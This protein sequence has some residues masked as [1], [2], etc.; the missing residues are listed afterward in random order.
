MLSE[1]KSMAL[2]NCFLNVS[3]NV[4]NKEKVRKDQRNSFCSLL[5]FIFEAKIYDVIFGVGPAAPTRNTFGA[6]FGHDRPIFFLLLSFFICFQW[7]LLLPLK[8]GDFIKCHSLESTSRRKQMIPSKNDEAK[9]SK[10]HFTTQHTMFM[11]DELSKKEITFF[12]LFSLALFMCVIDVWMCVWKNFSL[13]VFASSSLWCHR[14][15]FIGFAYSQ[16]LNFRFGRNACSQL[17][18]QRKNGKMSRFNSWL[19]ISRIQIRFKFRIVWFSSIQHH[20]WDWAVWSE[21]RRASN[22]ENVLVRLNLIYVGVLSLS[23]SSFWGDGQW[24]SR[25]ANKC[26]W[27]SNC[28]YFNSITFEVVCRS[29]FDVWSRESNLV[30]VYIASLLSIQQ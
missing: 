27:K 13:G 9:K 16:P 29:L 21:L 22:C 28:M 26:L 12:L 24:C 18:A 2:S 11:H 17:N 15:S 7:A 8:L 30:N 4:K 10:R 20:L 3:T 19:Y 1:W 14:L 23:L 5:Q 25:N 6:S